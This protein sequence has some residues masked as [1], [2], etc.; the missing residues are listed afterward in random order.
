LDGWVVEVFFVVFHFDI[1]H[2]I[3]F[4]L[5]DDAVARGSDDTVTA[6]ATDAT[7]EVICRD[8]WLAALNDWGNSDRSPGGGEV[9]SYGWAG[10]SWN[11]SVFSRQVF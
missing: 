4:F 8:S 9:S 11:V 3:I 7:E 2:R 5:D 1:F 6:E 10:S